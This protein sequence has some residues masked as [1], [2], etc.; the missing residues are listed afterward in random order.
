[1]ILGMY[2]LLAPFIYKIFK[3]WAKTEKELSEIEFKKYRDE[4]DKIFNSYV[5]VVDNIINN[6]EKFFEQKQI[7]KNIL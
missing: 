4:K 7:N 1:I 6:M 2:I 3:D 5:K